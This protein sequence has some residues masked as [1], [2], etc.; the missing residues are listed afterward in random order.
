[1]D[2]WIPHAGWVKGFADDAYLPKS[3]TASTGTTIAFD[4]PRTYGYA[5]AATG[6][7]T[8]NST[9]LVEGITQLLIHND[10]SEPTFG[11]E[12]KVL[13]GEY[14]PNVDNY[15]LMHAVK[16]DLI[17]VTISQEQ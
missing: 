6:N 13:S 1:G 12:F 10:S 2:L 11:T 7:I 17:L 3:S 16:S 5:T 15:I 14:V 9:G 8:L 4:V